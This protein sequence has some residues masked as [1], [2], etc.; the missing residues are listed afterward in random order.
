MDVFKLNDMKFLIQI[1]FIVLTSVAY[2]QRSYTIPSGFSL[3]TD[4][5]GNRVKVDHDFDRDGMTDVAILCDSEK[6]GMSMVVMLSRNYDKLGRYY[7]FPWDG[8][9]TSMSVTAK[10]VLVISSAFGNGRHEITLKL[11]YNAELENMRLI[12]Y[13]AS[14]MGNYDHEGAYS[15][16]VNL[17]TGNCIY[18]GKQEAYD[19]PVVTLSNIELHL[20]ALG[21]IGF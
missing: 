4:Y 17:L 16:S 7:Y 21:E 13:D 3:Y 5:D 10:N 14:N 9:G 8:I 6:H 11:R 12:G 2:S 18:N 1:V 15:L 20:D 19:I